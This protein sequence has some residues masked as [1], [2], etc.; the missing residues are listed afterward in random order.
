M[1]PGLK[2][3]LQEWWRVKKDK[4]NRLEVTSQLYMPNALGCMIAYT[5]AHQT[6]WDLPQNISID[7]SL[8]NKTQKVCVLVWWCIY[9]YEDMCGFAFFSCCACIQNCLEY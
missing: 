3:R 4:V 7:L 6:L 8:K 9:E 5:H 1:G 2:V